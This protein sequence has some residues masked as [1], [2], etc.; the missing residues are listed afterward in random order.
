V[1]F[2]LFYFQ[3][4]ILVDDG[5]GR[6]VKDVKSNEV[7]IGEILSVVNKEQVIYKS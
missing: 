4:L 6:L 7:V 5:G 2:F 1:C 3:G